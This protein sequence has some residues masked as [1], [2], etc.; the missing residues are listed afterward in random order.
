MTDQPTG[1][2]EEAV[3]WHALSTAETLEHQGVTTEQGLTAAEADSRRAKYGANKFA[4]AAKEPRWQAFLRQ[5]KDPMQ[6]VLLGAGILSLFLPGQVP[7]GVVLIGLTLFNAAMGLNQEG[8]ASAS[9]AA[10]QKMM[11]V[12]AKTRRDGALVELAMADLVPGDIVNIEAG[13]LVPADGRILTAATLEIDESA[14]TGESVPVPKQTDPVAADSALGDRIDLAFMNTQVTRGAA[15]MVV[16]STGMS[17]E[18][19]HISGMLQVAKDEETPLTKQLN[20][21]TNQI[22]VIAGVALAISIGIGLWRDTPF[23]VLFLTAIAFS[24]S[25]IP[26][27]LPGGRHRD[28]VDGDHEA[29]RGRRHR[30]APPVGRDARLDVRDQ[31]GQDRDA[32]AQPDD[33]RPDGDRQSPLHDLRRGLLDGGSDRP[34]RR[35]G[36]RAARAV[37]AADGPLRRRRGQGRRARRRPDRGRPRRARG[38]GWGRSDASHASSTRASRRSPSTPP[39]SSWPRST[40]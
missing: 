8:K 4:E 37:A 38:Q 14:L 31:L 26:T 20:S 35:P 10:L 11:V 5:Y 34:H 40:G 36:R 30:Q 25:A 12:K 16:T 17:T 15:T 18:V 29:R 19:G 27:G 39:T 21:L 28:P 2:P 6:I 1:A 22:L 3:A 32:H 23:D 9:V 33:R 13:D 7:T 24:V